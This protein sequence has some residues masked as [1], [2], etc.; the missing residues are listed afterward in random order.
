MVEGNICQE[1]RSKNINE[2]RNYFLQETR[3]NELRSKRHKTF[4]ATLSY[5]EHF[6]ILASTTNGCISCSTFASL[7]DIPI[8][9]T[10][11]AVGSKLYVIT[12]EIKKY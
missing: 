4:C 5:I 11:S 1:F 7:T 2:A 6:L 9:I 3:Q 12:E 8:G 10:S